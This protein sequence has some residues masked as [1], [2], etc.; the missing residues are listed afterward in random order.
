MPLCPANNSGCLVCGAGNVCQT[1]DEANGFVSVPGQ[2]YCACEDGSFF[3]GTDC[4]LCNLTLDACDL[5]LSE[6]LCIECTDNFTLLQGVCVCEPQYYQFD[7]D[8]CLSCE[9]GCL[10]CT[11]P[12]SCT[13]C[14]VD[15]SFELV[16]GVCQ[17]LKGMFLEN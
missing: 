10:E 2:P 1:C 12:T 16:G 17:C 14:D 5:C 13:T 11:G 3:D 4:V 9:V 15:N 7:S 6:V 8:T